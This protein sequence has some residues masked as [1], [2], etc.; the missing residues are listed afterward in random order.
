MFCGKASRSFVF[1]DK[2]GDMP[3]VSEEYREARRAEILAAARRCF[4]RQGF[5]DTSLQ[6][7][8]A[9][10]GVSSGALY[11]YF[12][13]KEEM[14][15]AIA[16]E[17][18]SQVISVLREAATG[19]RRSSP[20]AAL[21]HVLD[22]IRTKHIDNGFAAMT[23]M[24][25]SEALRNPA[26]AAQLTALRDEMGAYYGGLAT[27]IRLPTGV[28]GDSFATVLGSINA[29]FILQ[30][31]LFGPDAAGDLPATARALW[32]ADKAS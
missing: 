21:A 6:D 4:I 20:G 29:G 2:L 17:N 14:I 11:N 10:A 13:S 8:L 1:F 31:A 28:P 9:E 5:Q 7:I 16:E 24:V 32:P 3:K 12:R 30:L 25:W 18:I 15:V 22:E 27:D 23:V 19:P 26:L